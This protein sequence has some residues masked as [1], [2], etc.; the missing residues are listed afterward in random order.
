MD[1]RSFEE[2]TSRNTISVDPVYAR[3]RREFPRLAIQ[4]PIAIKHRASATWQHGT[5][6]NLSLGGTY[7]ITDQEFADRSELD[8]RL[9]TPDVL[10][11][12]EPTAPFQFRGRVL[13]VDR[14]PGQFGC[15][16]EFEAGWTTVAP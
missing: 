15:A 7:F 5:T 12:V 11:S 14:Q 8:I 2:L 9:V 13:R 3:E 1:L 6:K 10:F 16:V 4:Q